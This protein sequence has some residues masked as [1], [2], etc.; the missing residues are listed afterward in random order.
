MQEEIGIL[1]EQILQLRKD[2]ADD[3]AEVRKLNEQA[4]QL[5]AQI[6]R[7]PITRKEQEQLQSKLCVPAGN[8]ATTSCATL[9]RQHICKQ[10]I[11]QLDTMALVAMRCQG[12]STAGQLCR[13]NLQCT[14][15]S[16]QQNID[17]RVE[18]ET[19]Q[20]AQVAVELRNTHA[21]VNTA[22]S[23]L[24]DAKLIGTD[25]PDAWSLSVDAHGHTVKEI[26]RQADLEVSAV[27]PQILIP[28]SSS[29]CCW[30]V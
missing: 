10:R 12:V 15:E 27:R 5:K 29:T 7:Q 3:Q 26:L 9:Q 19:Q 13:A 25:A 24:R 21:I 2:T 6:K 1:D 11:L 23:C 8:F 17:Q 20:Q 22:N 16:V 18:E 4:D 28:N 30:V 14:K